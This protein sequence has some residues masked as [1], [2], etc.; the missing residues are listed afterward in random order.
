MRQ[1]KKVRY[2]IQAFLQNMHFEFGPDLHNRI[3]VELQAG[4]SLQAFL[5]LI[6]CEGVMRGTPA[7]G[8]ALAK[9]IRRMDVTTTCHGQT[10]ITFKEP[11]VHP[12]ADTVPEE[13]L[14]ETEPL[15]S[16]PYGD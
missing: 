7:F 3:R 9:S 1:V 13:D 6:I 15:T 16:N 8:S 14:P 4:T 12:D 10:V 5:Y 11:W 2:A